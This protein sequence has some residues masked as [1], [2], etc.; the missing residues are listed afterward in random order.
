MA[1]TAPKAIPAADEMMINS[2]FVICFF[3][4]M[5]LSLQTDTPSMTKTNEE[6]KTFQ[7]SS[8]F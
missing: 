6:P 5:A 1:P 7:K 3:V 4:F 2:F 8:L